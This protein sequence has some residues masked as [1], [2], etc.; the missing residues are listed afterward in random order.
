M[1]AGDLSVVFDRAGDRWTHRL[2]LG[3][4]ALYA[5]ARAIESDAERDAPRAS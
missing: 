3:R 1:S 5:E 4:P 2:E